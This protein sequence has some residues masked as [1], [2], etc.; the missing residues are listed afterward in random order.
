M[1]PLESGK[2]GCSVKGRPLPVFPT[3]Q[4]LSNVAEVCVVRNL[5]VTKIVV[6]DAVRSRQTVQ[7]YKMWTDAKY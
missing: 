6:K 4:G 3:G 7:L 5:C 2:E 1:L